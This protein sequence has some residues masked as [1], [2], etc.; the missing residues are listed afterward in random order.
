MCRADKNNKEIFQSRKICSSKCGLLRRFFPVLTLWSTLIPLSS[1]RSVSSEGSVG[2]RATEIFFNGQKTKKFHENFSVV[3]PIEF[4]FHYR[5]SSPGE[6]SDDDD[7]VVHK[8]R[9]KFQA[10]NILIAFAIHENILHIVRLQGERV[11]E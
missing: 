8:T 10:L 11:A 7:Y 3:F 4:Q 1:L 6:P 5:F 9:Q 2:K